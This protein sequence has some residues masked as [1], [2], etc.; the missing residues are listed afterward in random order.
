MADATNV[1][2]SGQIIYIKDATARS[3]LTN[4][5]DTALKGAVN[6]L[7][8]L[9]SDGKVPDSQLS[10]KIVNEVISSTEPSDQDNGD[11]WVVYE[12]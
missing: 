5:L 4:K 8:E 12:T 1:S 10:S 9:G 6:G 3:G 11:Y 7:A 2:I